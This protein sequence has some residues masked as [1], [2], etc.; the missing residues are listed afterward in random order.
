M[1]ETEVKKGP[2]RTSSGPSRATRDDEATGQDRG[3]TFKPR[4]NA[5]E[6]LDS[7][8]IAAFHEVDRFAQGEGGI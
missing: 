5:L 7:G 4:Q 8:G 6:R 3:R 1:T 2:G